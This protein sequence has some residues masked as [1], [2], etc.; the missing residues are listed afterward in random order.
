MD[1]V[2]VQALEELDEELRLTNESAY[3]PPAAAQRIIIELLVNGRRLR[4]LVDSGSE[5]N[6]MTD[7]A[8][9]RAGLPQKPLPRPTTVRLALDADQSTPIVLRHYTTA[10][11]TDPD[12]STTFDNVALTLGPI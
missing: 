5:I 4:A 12:S 2:S 9:V 1:P 3:V 7:T 11:F 10:S 8:S 6:L